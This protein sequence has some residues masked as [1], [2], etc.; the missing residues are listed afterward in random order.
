VGQK[1]LFER[2]LSHFFRFSL[3]KM[4]EN[5]MNERFPAVRQPAVD[6]RAFLCIAAA[7]RARQ[8]RRTGL[9]AASTPPQMEVPV[10]QYYL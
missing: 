1:S 10:E 3:H 7:Q 2:F 9:G 4:N 6:E 8:A 5:A